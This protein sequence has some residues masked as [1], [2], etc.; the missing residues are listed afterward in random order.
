MENETKETPQRKHPRLDNYDY[1]S[2]GLYFIT[3]CSHNRKCIFSR[4]VERGLTG[5]PNDHRFASGNPYTP[6]L[7]IEYKEYGRIAEKQLL[8]LKNRYPTLK[9]YAYVI[10][11]NHIHMI[12]NPAFEAAGA[13]P[14]PTVMD[15]I[16]TFKSLTTRECK[17]AYPTDKVFQNSFYEHIIRNKEEYAEIMKYIHDNPTAWELDSLYSNN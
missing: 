2:A 8:Q 7:K 13:S 14:R 11:P 15:I 10:M 16:C 3:I 6:D 1:S 5:T 12:I 4:I 17:K 9:I